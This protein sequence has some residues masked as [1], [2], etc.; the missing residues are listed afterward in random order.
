[1]KVTVQNPVLVT[2]A[3]IRSEGSVLI[4]R[5]PLKA[6]VEPGKWEF[7]GG[8]VERG[9]HPEACLVREIREELDLD[10]AVDRYFDHSAYAYG[11]ESPVHIVLLCYLCRVTGRVARAVEA[12]EIRWVTKEE[13]MDFDY[14][15]AD[16]P[17][18][19]RLFEEWDHLQI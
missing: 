15:A 1:M 2:A 19:R 6:R 11:E 16:V 8:K 3:I 5:R 18:V 7:P 17:L 12:E 10:I 9:E 14:A 4:A 13:L